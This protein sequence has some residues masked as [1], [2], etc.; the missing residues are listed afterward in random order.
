MY[1]RRR[2]EHRTSAL[3]KI[4]DTQEPIPPNQ[5][6]V[7][8]R[9]ST[10]AICRKRPAR[11]C[12]CTLRAPSVAPLCTCPARCEHANPGNG[13]FPQR[14]LILP[15]VC[16]DECGKSPW[17]AKQD[18]LDFLS[19]SIPTRS[20]GARLVSPERTMLEISLRPTILSATSLM[21]MNFDPKML[22]SQVSGRCRF[23]ARRCR[24]SSTKGLCCATLGN[25]CCVQRVKLE[26]Q[27]SQQI[28]SS[29]STAQSSA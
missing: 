17:L 9:T 3:L 25:F 13:V 10:R 5:S 16:S 12:R 28:H 18:A 24:G 7:A 19:S 4:S 23:E 11:S 21:V 26:L 15:L 2:F 22:F 8:V 27:D 1:L 6:A 20:D 29:K 14:L